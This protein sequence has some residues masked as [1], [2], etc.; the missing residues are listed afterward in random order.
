LALAALAVGEL[1]A[2]KLPTTPARTIPPALLFR[3][4]SG[5]FSGRSLAVSLDAD[6]AAGAVAGTLGALIATYAG[7]AI[8]AEVV[9]YARLPDPLVALAED[10]LAL[11]GAVAVTRP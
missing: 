1:I 3:A 2:D 7:M 8:R 9:R 4:L 6:R 11:A 10:A 5:G